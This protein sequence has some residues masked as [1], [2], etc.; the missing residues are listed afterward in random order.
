ML[1]SPNRAAQIVAL[2]F[3]LL[4]NCESAEK[5]I[6]SKGNASVEKIDTFIAAPEVKRL[7]EQ[8]LVTQNHQN[9]PFVVIDKKHTQVYLF[10]SKGHLRGFAPALIG[11]ALGDYSASGIGNR[12][13]SSIKLEERTTPAGRFVASLGFNLSG[14]QILWVDYETAISMHPVVTSNVSEH[15]EQ[16]LATKSTEDNRISYGCINVSAVFF[17]NIVMPSFKGASGIVYILPDT[18]AIQDFF[19]FY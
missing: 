9:L 11:S 12:K 18:H 13:L 16:R 10:D 17:R 8:I 7:R 14:K 4:S 5:A 1:G 2:S 6:S 15:R 19:P 3:C